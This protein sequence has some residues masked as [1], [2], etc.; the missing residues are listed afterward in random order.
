MASVYQ[1]SIALTEGDGPAGA[2]LGYVDGDSSSIAWD[3]TEVIDRIRRVSRPGVVVSVAGKFGL[4]AVGGGLVAGEETGAVPAV[5]Y[6]PPCALT[7]LGDPAFRGAH[8]LRFAYCSGA[9]ANGI[10]SVAIVKAMGAAGMLGFFGAAGLSLAEV[11]EA[12]DQLAETGEVYPYGFNLIHSPNESDLEEAVVDLYLRKGVRLIEA[13]AYLALT[14]AVVRYRVAGIHADAEGGVVTPNKIIAKISRVEVAEQFL[15]PPPEKMLRALVARGVITEAQAALAARVPMA[16]DITAE[17]DSGGHTDRRP[18][19]ALLPTI[20]ALRDRMQEQFGYAARPRV[21]LAG[22]IST[23]ASAAGAFAMGAAYV[24]VGSVNQACV[25]SGSSDTV[26]EMLAEA[27]QADIAM[28]PAADMFEMGVEVQVLK[29]GTMFAMRGAK[30]YELYRSYDSLEAIPEAERVKLEKTIFHA[31][32]A[33]VWAE[34]AAFFQERD[35]AQVLRAA[36]DPKHKMA[37]LFRWYLGQSSR[38][39]NRGVADRKVD[40][41][42]WCGPAMGAFNEWARG[43]Y[44]ESPVA[45]HVADVA[46]NI[47]YGAAVLARCQSLRQQGFPLPLDAERIVPQRADDLKEYL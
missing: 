44:L 6:L 27:R 26:R 5:G 34:T 14:S 45:R 42:V 8:G 35:P 12:I 31:P 10:G 38:W 39:A 11:E 4:A 33:T 25:E 23:P 28:A 47:L 19:I 21:G 22:G 9:M 24:V 30:L 7:S 13:S 36:S 29:R 15:S 1:N 40:Y 16:E 46:L 37:L 17:A 43:T 20:M 18:A 41:Q 32:L 2:L 3:D